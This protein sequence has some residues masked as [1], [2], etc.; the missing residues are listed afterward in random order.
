M[1]LFTGVRERNFLNAV[2]FYVLKIGCP[3]RLMSYSASGEVAT[4][5]VVDRL[6]TVRRVSP[7]ACPPRTGGRSLSRVGSGPLAVLDQGYAYFYEK[8]LLVKANVRRCCFARRVSVQSGRTISG[9]EWVLSFPLPVYSAP[10]GLYQ[11][12]GRAA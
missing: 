10:G 4:T 7:G 9:K 8:A 6:R 12:P 2:F 11:A 5:V 1:P 3:W